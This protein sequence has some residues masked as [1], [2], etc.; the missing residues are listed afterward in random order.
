MAREKWEWNMPLF[1]EA[2]NDMA[3]N[4]K[5]IEGRVPDYT[6]IEKDYRPMKIGDIL[7]FFAVNT[8]FSPIEDK[9]DIRKEVH[10]ILHY[11][12]VEELIEQEGMQN[13]LPAAKSLD[14]ALATY[15]GFPEYPERVKKY[16]VYAIGLI[17]K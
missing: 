14:E 5:K 17:D 15:L 12:S 11:S 8:N 4:S 2:Y 3:M 1:T 7:R 13:L 9:P 6:K 16:G 10:F